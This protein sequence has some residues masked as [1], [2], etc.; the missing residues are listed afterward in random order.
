MRTLSMGL[1]ALLATACAPPVTDENEFLEL[2][3]TVSTEAPVAWDEPS[4]LGFS[5]A[6]VVAVL[7][8]TRSL[9]ATTTGRIP[10]EQHTLTFHFTPGTEAHV[11]TRDPDETVG[12]PCVGGTSLAFDVQVEVTAD[13]GWLTASGSIPVYAQ[14]TTADLVFPEGDLDVAPSAALIDA[15]YADEAAM[16]DPAECTDPALPIGMS[17]NAFFAPWSENAGLLGYQHCTLV[18]TLFLLEPPTP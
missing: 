12:N 10:D 15:A 3:P 5:A 18:S 1:P 14:G 9:A 16:R 11:E 6:D 7:E 13:D 17:L 2:C 8:G 4:S